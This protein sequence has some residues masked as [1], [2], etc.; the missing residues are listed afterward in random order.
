MSVSSLNEIHLF[1]DKIVKI[2]NI[3]QK[4]QRY[5]RYKTQK[6]RTT[7]ERNSVNIEITCVYSPHAYI[8]NSKRG[9]ERQQDFINMILGK[10]HSHSVVWTGYVTPM[11]LDQ[12]SGKQLLGGPSCLSP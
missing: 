1:Q 9:R 10:K 8:L 5:K 11:P 6:P 3:K 12:I 7:S 4:E 2:R